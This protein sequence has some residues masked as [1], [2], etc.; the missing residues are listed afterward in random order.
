MGVLFK[1]GINDL[2]LLLHVFLTSF[3]N[4]QHKI[5]P[6]T[7]SQPTQRAAYRDNEAAF[8]FVG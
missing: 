8:L 4:V 6:K 1:Q 3:Y 2:L 7:E 5:K